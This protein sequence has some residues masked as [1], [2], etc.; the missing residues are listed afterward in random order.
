MKDLKEVLKFGEISDVEFYLD[1]YE[2]IE[3]LFK[4]RTSPPKSFFE[5]RKLLINRLE[6]LSLQSENNN[7][8]ICNLD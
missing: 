5:E 1:Y 7:Q 2:M 4:H 6:E 3:E 8:L